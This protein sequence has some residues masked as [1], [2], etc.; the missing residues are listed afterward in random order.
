LIYFLVHLALF[1]CVAIGV[2]VEVVEDVEVYHVDAGYYGLDAAESLL[3][4]LQHY[5]INSLPPLKHLDQQL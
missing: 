4:A 5:T 3:V 2:F 1:E